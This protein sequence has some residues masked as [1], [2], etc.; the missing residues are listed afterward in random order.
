MPVHA[1]QPTMPSRLARSPR[2]ARVRPT[3]LAWALACGLL[4]CGMAWA[5]EPPPAPAPTNGNGNGQRATAESRWPAPLAQALKSSGL[6]ADAVSLGVWPVEDGPERLQHAVD[7]PR[8]A[9]SVMK[10]FTTGAGLRVLGPAYTWRT[11]VGLGGPV[12]ASGALDGP[13]YLRGQGDPSLVIEKLQLFMARWRAGGLREVRGDVVIDRSAFSVPPHDPAAFDGQSLKPYNAGPDALLLNHQAVT[14]R[15]APDAAQPETLRAS[16]EP[17]LHGVT[18]QTRLNAR[19]GV[20]C[21][22]WREALSLAITPMAGG[23]QDGRNRWR[24]ELKGSYPLS[25]GEREWPLLWTGDGPGDHTARVLAQSWMLAG[26]QLGGTV[27]EGTWPTDVPV[28]QTWTSPPLAQVI[29]DI[30]KFSNNVMAR[31]LFLTLALPER[32]P[33]TLEA[34]RQAVA[35]TV[36]Q[37]TQA[38]GGTPCGDEALVLDNGSGLSRSERTSARCL[39]A[40]L[41]GMWRSPL[42]PEFMSS[43]PINGQ[44][45]TTRRWQVGAG[46]AHIKT[47][48]LDGVSAVAG[49]VLADSGQRYIVIGLINHPRAS[50]GRP[51]LQAL[52]E[53]AQHDQ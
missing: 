46:Q 31:Q 18:L 16:L 47:G 27:R 37:A 29:R 38:N 5:Q 42:M 17:E 45:G 15:I 12:K 2:R 44:D 24:V 32:R 8:L 53:W 39:A 10:L 23:P 21:G 30:N 50:A 34:A 11:E 1:I 13:L 48:S 3:P 7:T 22:D 14:L 40:W 52:I 19:A 41:R 20:A 28:W 35:Q 6:P 49:Y 9:A 26:G 43:L 33:A 25:C 36:R 4:A 51:L